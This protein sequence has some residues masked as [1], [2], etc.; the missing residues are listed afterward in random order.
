FLFGASARSGPRGRRMQSRALMMMLPA[1]IPMAADSHVDYAGHLGGVI[2]GLV[3]GVVLQMVW[4]PGEDRPH[5][6][7][8][9]AGVGALALAI[10]LCAFALGSAQ[11]NVA[12]VMTRTGLIPD[13]RL[14]QG[15]AVSADEAADLVARYPRDPRAHLFRGIAFITAGHD[16]ADAEEQFRLAAN[17]NAAASAGLSEDFTKSAVALLAITLS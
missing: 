16:L 5:F 17:P 15:D 10:G 8:V 1:L 7:N 11:T 4:E 9:A 14:P 13:A 6:G 3:M 12:G 2:A